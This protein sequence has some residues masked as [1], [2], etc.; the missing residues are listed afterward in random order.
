MRLLAFLAALYVV[1]GAQ[2]QVITCPR[3]SSIERTECLEKNL[4]SARAELQ[5]V[6]GAA[7]AGIHSKDNDYIPKP[8]LDKWKVEAEK[9]QRAW[10]AYRDIECETI[11][12]YQWWGGSGAGGASL[13]CSLQKTVARIQEL[14]SAYRVK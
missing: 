4:Q 13:E 2:G 14:K 1:P 9:A 6:Y 10:Q 7:I 3:S 11:V 8:E 5:R 12:P